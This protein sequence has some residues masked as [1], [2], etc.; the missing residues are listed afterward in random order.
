LLFSKREWVIFDLVGGAWL[1]FRS[2]DD[3]LCLKDM[4]IDS[5]QFN[6][7]PPNQVLTQKFPVVGEK[8]SDPGEIVLSHWRLGI[9]NDG[10]SLGSFSFDVIRDL[11]SE[12]LLTDIHCVTGWSRLNA[13][14]Q[15]LR[16]ASLLDRLEIKVPE[17][18]RFIRFEAYSSRGHDTSLPILTALEDAWLVHSFDGKPITPE[19]GFPLRLVVPSRYFYKSLKWLKSIQFLEDDRLGFWERTTG[20]HNEADPWK[21]QRLDARRFSNRAECEQFKQLSDFNAYRSVDGDPKV[22]VQADFSGWNPLTRD[23]HGLQ[24]KSCDFSHAQLQGV[25]FRGANLTFGKFDG[26]NLEGADL[27]GADLEGCDFSGA[28]LQGARLHGCFLSAARFFRVD[29][30]TGLK[31]GLTHWDE[32]EMTCPDG[33]L[34]GQESYLKQ[35]GVLK[36]D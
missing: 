4:S 1:T 19:H 33:L 13:S 36:T 15:G 29:A 28:N 20:Y 35:L 18:A 11:P 27:T 34:E 16:L 8:V 25:D 32:M 6:R 21:E 14:F 2:D 30:R 9:W 10:T 22:I 17:S 26:A 24:L 31:T 3:C 7:L 12:Q 5:N 23:L